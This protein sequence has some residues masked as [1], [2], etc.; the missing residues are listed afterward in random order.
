MGQVIRDKA[1]KI[2][3]RVQLQGGLLAASQRNRRKTTLSLSTLTQR[4]PPH[5]TREIYQSQLR[6]GQAQ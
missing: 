2:K 5:R 3:G 4:L 1:T 6:I